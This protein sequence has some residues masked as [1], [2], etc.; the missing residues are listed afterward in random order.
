MD[1]GHTTGSTLLEAPIQGRWHT[2][3]SS[4]TQRLIEPLTDR[5]LHFLGCLVNGASNKEIARKLCVSENTVKFHLKNVYS[6]FAV[7]TRLQAVRAAIELG[8]LSDSEV[9]GVVGLSS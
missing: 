1:S 9:P 7:N 3:S 5:E 6:K 2:S 8:L 4:A